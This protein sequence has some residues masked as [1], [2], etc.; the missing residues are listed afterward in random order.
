M[1]VAVWLC[2]CVPADVVMSALGVRSGERIRPAIQRRLDAYIQLEERRDRL[3]QI[4]AYD[5]SL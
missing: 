1:G 2:G 3:R 5:D 4:M